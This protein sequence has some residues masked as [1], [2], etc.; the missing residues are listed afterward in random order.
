MS[1][2]EDHIFAN[3]I[4]IL[5]RN[6][7]NDFYVGKI[8][9]KAS[10]GMPIILHANAFIY[11]WLNFE[12]QSLPFYCIFHP[13]IRAFRTSHI[14]NAHV[15]ICQGCLSNGFNCRRPSPASDHASCDQISTGHGDRSWHATAKTMLRCSS[16]ASENCTLSVCFIFRLIC[17][18]K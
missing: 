12:A 13:P 3:T 11:E 1:S 5:E 18:A 7:L 8:S 14:R 9:F 15:Q 6:T 10:L 4:L 2:N 17:N 16:R